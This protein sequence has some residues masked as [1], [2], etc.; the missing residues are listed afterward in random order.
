[1]PRKAPIPNCT[2]KDKEALEQIV[3]SRTEEVRMVERA[4]IILKCLEGERVHKIAKDLNVRPNTVIEWRRRFEKD[5]IKGIKDRPRSGKPALYDEEFRNHVLEPWNFH[6][7]PV[8]PNGT[9]P[10]LQNISI[11]QWTQFGVCCARKT[12][13]SVGSAV[14]V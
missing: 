2:V 5:G 8:K 4:K 7:L 9:V 1:M 12:Y 11:L 3:R 13:V 10:Q 6:L 14:S